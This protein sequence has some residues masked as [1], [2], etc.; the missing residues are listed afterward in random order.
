M[1]THEGAE[2]KNGDWNELYYESK[3]FSDALKKAGLSKKIRD[4]IF[5]QIRHNGTCQHSSEVPDQIKQVFVVS[6]DIRVKD[7]VAM[8]AAL[9]RFTD[10]AI[11]KTINF[12]ATATPADVSQAYLNGWKQ[13]LKG[14][15]VYV[16]G[17][18]Q[19]VV[20]ETNQTKDQKPAEPFA[21]ESGITGK[22][23]KKQLPDVSVCPD[24]GSSMVLSEG[25]M[26]CPSCGYA[27]CGM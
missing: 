24:C 22:P 19:Q 14:M 23:L 4:K 13:G 8:Q 26:H 16:A 12:P 9:Q 10:N 6:G 5:E 18:R 7:H 25:C 11:S 1:K 21:S 27:K 20:L 3:T 2:T 17:S 15:T